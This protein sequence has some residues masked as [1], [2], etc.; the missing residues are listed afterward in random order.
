MVAAMVT[1][2]EVDF[3][4]LL[5]AVIHERDFKA[6]TTYPFSCMIIEFCSATGV[7]IWHIDVLRTPT[8][9]VDIGHIKNEANEVAHNRGPRVEV[10]PFGENL[11]NTVEQDKGVDHAS[12]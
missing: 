9:I 10:H 3:L 8:G 2:F 1:G 6:S 4:R 7:P 5:L 12:F 11:I